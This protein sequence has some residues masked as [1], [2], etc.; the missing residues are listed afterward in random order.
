MTILVTGASGFIG[1]H[2]VHNLTQDS[3]LPRVVAQIHNWTPSRWT[4]E[5]LSNS[6]RVRGDLRDFKFLKEVITR[7]EVKEVYHLGAIA[8]VKTAYQDP[9]SVYEVNV[10]GTVNVLEV[11][12]QADAKVLVMATD[13]IFGER[14]NACA[15]DSLEPSEPYATSKCCVDFIADSFHRTYGMKIARVRSCNVYG[16]DY[17]NRIVSNTIRA[18]IRGESPVI[19]EGE[20][21]TVRQYIHV[22]DLVDALKILQK[23]DWNG[24]ANVCTDD[25]LNQKDVVLAILK[26]FSEI[27]PT[28]VKR[29]APPE[30]LR[31]T[32]ALTDFGWK[33]KVGLNAGL[34]DTIA[35]F[36]KYGF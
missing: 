32:I 11:C 3:C 31:Q 29:K 12:R 35:R 22:F 5:A 30:I 18:C 7:Y 10:M 13:K 23:K 20:T 2:L 15:T 14:L 27:T 36:R 4:E 26:F 19:Y 6:V 8:K 16:L 17:E 33:S 28:F 25:V 1:S 24:P 34:V 21:E 9:I